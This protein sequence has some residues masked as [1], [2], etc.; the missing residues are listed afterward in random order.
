MF[1]FAV[2]PEIDTAA[3]QDLVVK[4]GQRIN[5]SVPIRGSP[6][7]TVKWIVN[8]VP[9]KIGGHADI[10]THGNETSLEIPFSA[11][12]D[13]GLYTLNL[14]NEFGMISASAHVTV[15]G[16]YITHISF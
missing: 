7:P 13:T 1:C 3:L 6:R 15:L 11:R 9:V 2:A 12:S 8:E 14:S 16:E 10:E 4:A 5:F